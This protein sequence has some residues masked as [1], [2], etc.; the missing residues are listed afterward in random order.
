M[1]S[2]IIYAMKV[3]PQIMKNGVFSVSN[4]WI[5]ADP[6]K[7]RMMIIF[8]QAY[9]HQNLL[10]QG[11]GGAFAMALLFG[12]GELSIYPCNVCELAASVVAM[13]CFARVENMLELLYAILV[14][15]DM[16]IL[17]AA[18]PPRSCAG[19]HYGTAVL[20]ACTCRYLCIFESTETQARSEKQVALPRLFLSVA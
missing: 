19:L 18:L 9:E 7:K 15:S 16:V 11:Q 8:F 17:P 14:F 3:C 13:S 4:E 10:S 5:A 2:Q 20:A 6:G 1:F 12:E